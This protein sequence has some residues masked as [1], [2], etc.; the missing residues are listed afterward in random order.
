MSLF[1]LKLWVACAGSCALA[2]WMMIAPARA[3]EAADVASRLELFVDDHLIDH[4]TDKAELRL[5]HPVP[6]EVAIATDRPWE[7]NACNYITVFHDGDKYRIYY[8]GADVLYT[9]DGSRETHRE[10]TCYAESKDGVHWSKPDLGLFEFNGSKAN[11]IVWDGVGTHNFAPFR[12]GNP[13]CSA[14]ARYKAFGTGGGKRGMYAFQSADALRW[15]LMSQDPVITKGAFDSQN[16][17]FWDSV[18]GE[19]R[20]YHRDFRN[21]RDIRTGTSKD[22]LTWTEP[23]F[24]QYAPG[25]VSELYTNQ[26]IPYYRAPHLFLGFPTRYT[27]RGWTESAKALPRPE[28]RRLRGAKSTREGT[29]VT[30]GMFMTSRD[31]YHFSVWPE[32]FIRPG[33]RL[34]DNW[35]YG[36][37]YQNWGLVETKSTLPDGPNEISVY[38]TEC[39]MQDRPGFLRR[40]TLRVDGFVSVQAPLGGG[41]FVTK[42]LRFTGKNLVLNGSTSG[43]GSIRIELQDA[44]GN[45]LPGFALADCAELYGDA[46]EMHVH[47]KRASDLGKF[48][49]QPIRLRFA[50]RDADVY[51]FS[52]AD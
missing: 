44:A 48:A 43:A 21:G 51:A 13:R 3:A 42:P 50:L 52:F 5:H 1:H 47:W 23:V 36:D 19:Y 30:D 22:F 10:V 33:L 34:R 20:E 8:R 29:A 7:G 9:A 24:L 46:L 2:I 14:A 4:L 39:S 27:D 12:D 32:S 6:R 49:G 26:V 25:R 35:F 15:S 11:N 31:G 28:Y 37:N 17:G 16:L 38:V 40:H 41:E 18:R 45:P